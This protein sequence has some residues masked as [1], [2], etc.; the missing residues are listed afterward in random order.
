MQHSINL[1]APE[2]FTEIQH[3]FGKVSL[4]KEQL[5]RYV[6]GYTY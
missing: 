6:R 4:F 2:V 3:K 1:L 5:S